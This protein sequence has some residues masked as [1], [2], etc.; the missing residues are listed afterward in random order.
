MKRK[1]LVLWL[2]AIAITLAAAIYQRITGP[3]NPQHIT[4]KTEEGTEYSFTHPFREFYII[5]GIP[6]TNPGRRAG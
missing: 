2:A 6:Y 4:I 5:K 3:S 1:I